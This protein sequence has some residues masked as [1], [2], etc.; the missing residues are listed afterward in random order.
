MSPMSII[1]VKVQLFKKSACV[2]ILYVGVKLFLPGGQLMIEEG[3]Y[4]VSILYVGV[5][6]FLHDIEQ[7]SQG[8][9]LSF[10]PLCWSQ[11]IPT[12]PLRRLADG[13]NRRSFNPLCWSQV[14][15][16]PDESLKDEMA[17]A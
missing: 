10:N 15:P 4:G 13:Q 16:T 8:D 1:F 5:K 2:S 17:R 12:L 14:I 6:L 9:W 11:V 7:D 3:T